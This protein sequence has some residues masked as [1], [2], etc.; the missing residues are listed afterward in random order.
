MEI[1]NKTI[2]L[3]TSFSA[4]VD[5]TS[6]VV[7]DEFRARL[8]AVLAALRLAG[9]EV[10]CAI[11]AEDWKIASKPPGVSMAHNFA[12]IEAHDIFLA[13]VDAA[14]SDGRGVEV[15][16][17]YNAGKQ[18]VVT[19]GPNEKLGW[20]LNEL[21]AMERITYF[22]YETPEDLVQKLREVH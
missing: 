9:F 3:A 19:T 7:R 14:G 1:M 10:Y 18:V 5:P 2:F 15:E 11:E 8:E 17:A 22:P 4:H 12:Q 16:H 21:V 13:L 20:V 6:G